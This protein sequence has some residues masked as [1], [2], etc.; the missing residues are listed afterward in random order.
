MRRQRQL[1]YFLS[2]LQV[3]ILLLFITALPLWANDAAVEGV[4]GSLKPMVEHPSIQ[5]QAER[6]LKLADGVGG[7]SFH[8]LHCS[9]ALRACND[10]THPEAYRAE[11]LAR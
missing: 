10:P 11:A 5:M 8:R 1:E 4:G 3:I 6:V 9:Y 7:E 2:V